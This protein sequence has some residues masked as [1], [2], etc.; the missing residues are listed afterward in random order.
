MMKK[1]AILY[2]QPPFFTNLNINN[3]QNIFQTSSERFFS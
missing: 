2:E 3:T 1:V